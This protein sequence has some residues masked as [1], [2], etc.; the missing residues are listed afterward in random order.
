MK[1]FEIVCR[2]NYRL[3]G[4][5]SLPNKDFKY[6]IYL[7]HGMCEHKERYYDFMEYLSSRGFAAL[8]C[9]LRGHGYHEEKEKLG[10]FGDKNALV[11]DVT[12][13]ISYIKREYKDKKIILFGHSMGSLITRNYIQNNDNEIEKVILCGPPTINRFAVV[14][15]LLST[16]IGSFK[17]EYYRSKFIYNLSLGNYNKGFKEKN[18]WLVSDKEVLNEYNKDEYCGFIFTTNGF[19]SLFYMLRNAY[20]DKYK[21]HNKNM[22]ILLITGTNDKVVGTKKK[23]EHLFKFLIKEGYN[24]VET[25]EYEGLR[26]ELLNEHGKEK[27]YERVTTFIRGNRKEE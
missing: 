19:I 20:K 13:V 6:I 17:G 16:L 5:I 9:D 2:D 14:G 15:T 4:A 7:I 26:H 25:E 27:V 11:D 24:T 21:V 22:P 18:E 3:Y 10:Y 8:I 12:E 1:E 23:F